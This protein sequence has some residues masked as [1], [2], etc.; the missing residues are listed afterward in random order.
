V[1]LLVLLALLLYPSFLSADGATAES[2]KA[3][4]MAALGRPTL[5]ITNLEPLSVAGRGFK[6]GERV[7]VRFESRRK[8]TTA[9][10]AGRFVVRF[11]NTSCDGGTI[12][13]IGSKGSRAVANFSPLLC[14]EP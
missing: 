2:G 5:V 1:L 9:T 10:R 4:P 12:V 3:T 6:P 11:A 8:A 13:A 14:V 7:T